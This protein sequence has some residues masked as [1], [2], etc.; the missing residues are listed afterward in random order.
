M[1]NVKMGRIRDRQLARNGA[2]IPIGHD[3][4]MS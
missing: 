2:I 4:G 3:R 1:E